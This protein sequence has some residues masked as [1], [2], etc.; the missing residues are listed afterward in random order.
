MEPF[1][2]SDSQSVIVYPDSLT[3][4]Q[5]VV[6]RNRTLHFSGRIDVG[7]FML[8]VKDCDF[9]YENF[10]FNMPTI[11]RMEFFVPDF[12]DKKYEQLVRTPL[13]NL[14]G[15]LEVDKP[16]NHNGMKKNKEYPIFKSLENSNVFYDAPDI[17]GG[18]YVRDR[19]YYT[20]LPFTIN[21][22]VDF[23]TDSLQ[24]TGVLTSGGIF[25]DIPQPLTVQ[26]DYYL[27]FNI[28]TPAGGYPAYGG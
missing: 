27:G 26:K 12:K 22:M 24:F 2:V 10:S 28:S 17:Q 11:Q 18:Q 23:V 14:V 7:K 6:G 8:T 3:G 5:V 25:P 1:V 21:S 16:D 19:F 20:L 9:S 13:S 4:R 15:T